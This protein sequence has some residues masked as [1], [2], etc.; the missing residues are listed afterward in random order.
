LGKKK[1]RKTGRA[2][3]DYITHFVETANRLFPHVLFHWE[4][5]GR[6]NAQTILDGYQDKITTFNDDIQGTG[7]MMAAAVYAVSEITK[8]PLTQHS[9]LIFGGGTAGVGISDQ[10]RQ[11]MMLA[12]LSESESYAQFYMVDRQGLI[13]SDMEG[14]TEGQLRYARKEIDLRGLTHLADIVDAVQ[15]SILIGCSGQAGAFTQDVVQKMAK[16]NERPAI[17]PISNPAVLCEATAENLITWTDGQALVVTGSPSAN[18]EY[19]GVSYQIG[20]ANNA[21]LY[22]GL[23]LGIIVA[24]ASR[25]TKNMLSKAANAISALQDLKADGAPILPPLRFVREASQIVAEAVVQAAID[26]AVATRL[27][28]NIKEAIKNEIWEAMYN[29]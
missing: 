6:G 26:D 3:L 4:D 12:G 15:P 27:I 13:T 28:S 18:V 11:E 23:G 9:Y 14:L 17:L 20:Q 1:P 22:P 24:K 5:F 29:D 16:Y 10:I 21:L 19:K 8:K 2:Y 25:V 7:I